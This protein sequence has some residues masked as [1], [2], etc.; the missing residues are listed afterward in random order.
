MRAYSPKE[1][2]RLQIP[3]LPLE[4]EWR[5]AFG[6]PSRYE[7]WFIDGES[8]SGK[9]TFVM[10]LA[11]E[12]CQF[13][14]VDY[15]PLEEGA[16]LS[17]KRRTIRL[18]MDEVAGRFKAVTNI[19]MEELAERLAKP[20][21]ANFIVID[22]VQYTGMTFPKIKALLLDRFPRKSFIFVSQNYK[23]KPKG[24]LAND[25]KF[26][27][28]VKISTIGFRAYCHGRYVDGAGAYF[29]IWEEGA[30]KYYLN[31]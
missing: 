20:K 26:D 14:K 21:S 9:S 17:F 4:G 29:T 19:T 22:S 10:A 25:L 28:G 13:G 3:E 23:G 30:Y 24:K 27:A 7:R 5:A 1:I 12:L 15:I 6:R 8:T 2:A 31:R 16:N 18:Q 11:K